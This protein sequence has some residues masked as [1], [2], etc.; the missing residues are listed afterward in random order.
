MDQ[1]VV[2]LLSTGKV[3]LPFLIDLHGF[4]VKKA[5]EEVVAFFGFG[6]HGISKVTDSQHP[7]TSQAL[8]H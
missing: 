5:V 1:F 8:W 2:F 4:E 6:N 7:L 3:E